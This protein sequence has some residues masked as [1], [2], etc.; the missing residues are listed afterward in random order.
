MAASSANS[1]RR[2]RTS[3]P[4]STSASAFLAPS[5]AT[6]FP[7]RPSETSPPYGLFPD[8]QDE[9]LRK[10]ALEAFAK[11]YGAAAGKEAVMGFLGQ[12]G[13]DALKGADILRTAPERYSSTVEYA[14]NG[15]AKSLR[16]AA[17]VMFADFGSRIFYTQHGGYDTHAGLKTAHPQLW[18]ELAP[19]VSDFMDDLEEHGHADDTAI[20]IFSRV[21]APR[22]RQRQRRQTMA[23]AA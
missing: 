10:Y 8:L 20:L 3:S 15:I 21:R 9:W 12:T 23:P 1:T 19:A 14:G 13:A 18:S 5:A 16:D 6:A 11:M 4:P 2:A 22:P 7:S 17:Q